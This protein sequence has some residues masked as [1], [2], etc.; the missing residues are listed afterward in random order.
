MITHSQPFLMPGPNYEVPTDHTINPYTITNP[1][2]IFV[3]WV[4]GRWTVAKHTPFSSQEPVY[5]SRI[6]CSSIEE[7][8]DALEQYHAPSEETPNANAGGHTCHED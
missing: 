8:L 6:R 5:D 7:A 1:A 4:D 3:V 2:T